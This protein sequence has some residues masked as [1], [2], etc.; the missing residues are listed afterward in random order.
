MNVRVTAKQPNSRMCMVCGLQNPFG[1]QGSYYELENGDLV[2]VF[3]P[4]DQHQSYPGRMHGGITA[5]VLDETIGRAILNKYGEMVWGVT[6]DFTVRYRKPVPLGVEL[7]AVGRI[8]I[9]QGRL[10]EGTGEL[11]LPDG[12]V[13]AEASGKYMKMPIEKIADF[14]V[15]AQEWKVTPRPDDPGSIAVLDK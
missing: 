11:L 13:A 7:R 6:V 1:L 15:D 4:R 12:T 3:T 9:D 14:D 5:A 2:C 10:F 8:T